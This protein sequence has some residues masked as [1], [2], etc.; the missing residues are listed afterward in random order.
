M[1]VRPSGC[2]RKDAAR[3]RVS[4]DKAQ[5]ITRSHSKR[6]H[7]RKA[8]RFAEP[9]RPNARRPRARSGP[10]ESEGFP[11]GSKWSILSAL[12]RLGRRVD[13]EGLFHGY[14]SAS[15]CAGGEWCVATRGSRIL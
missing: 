9:A 4:R 10:I 2:S 14:A 5:N 15:D 7:G 13:G 12:I 3:K 11:P 1:P 8:K 6:R